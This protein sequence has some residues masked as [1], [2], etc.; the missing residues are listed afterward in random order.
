MKLL[1]NN[2]RK[3]CGT[4]DLSNWHLIRKLFE[5]VITRVLCTR[6]RGDHSFAHYISPKVVTGMQ[7]MARTMDSRS[8]KFSFSSVLTGPYVY[9]ECWTPETG[10]S[11]NV[12][13][14]HHPHAVAA[15]KQ[16][17]VVG[18]I[19]SSISNPCSYALLAG[20]TI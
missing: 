3:T 11:L 8:Y 9:K 4:F 2:S 16:E 5:V 14:Q 10:E 20:S 13:N 17:R 19:P 6:V 18:H 12:Q 15:F 1:L 7:K